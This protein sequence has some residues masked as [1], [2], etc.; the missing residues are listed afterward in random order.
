MNEIINEIAG[1]LGGLM[2]KVFVI[3]VPL[4]TFLEWAKSQ[5]W[6]NRMVNSV[7]PL[8]RPV[9]FRQNALFPLLTGL[10]FGISYGA[11]VLIP[12]ARSGELDPK[13]I[14]L[15]ASFLGI[16][17]ALFED[18]LLFVAVG[19]SAWILPATR[20]AAALMIVSALARLPWP[21]AAPDPQTETVS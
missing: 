11:G 13:Q 9:G 18:T 1:G 2:L 10:I 15:V 7:E 12:Q 19:A 3:V 8:F 16:C 6:F 17:H 20:F 14:F 21:L 4:I 5:R